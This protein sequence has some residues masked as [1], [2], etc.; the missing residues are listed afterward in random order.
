ME[1]L[2]II[3][4]AIIVALA[5][6][7]IFGKKLHWQEAAGQIGGISLLMVCIVF[8]CSASKKHDTEILNGHVTGKARVQVSCEH[9]YPCHCYSYSCGTAKNP[10]TCQ[11]CDTCYEHPYDIDWNVEATTGLTS[12]TFQVARLDSQGLMEPPRWD[13]F[14]AGDPYMQN[15]SYDNYVKANADTIYKTKGFFAMFKDQIP[16]YP[17]AIQDYHTKLD[18]MLLVGTTLPDIAAWNSD[19]T[20]LNC[21]I[22]PTKQCN[23][24]MIVSTGMPESFYNAVNEAW[25]GGK[26]NDIIVM[27]DQG[28]DGSI[29]WV[30]VISWAKN[31]IMRVKLRDDLLAV[32]RMN[33]SSVMNILNRDINDYFVRKRMREFKYLDSAII[34]SNS[35]FWW[36]LVSALLLSIAISVFIDLNEL[37]GTDSYY[38]RSRY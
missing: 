24:L 10:S 23:I 34:L 15:Y 38:R 29:D 17:E 37:H 11:H 26:K 14:N 3:F 21:N 20:S 25:I 5:N 13:Q 16:P 19:L 12:E 7:A 35:E 33:R 18:R 28:T 22:G 32:G 8:G 30:N 2:G 27:V 4:P 6:W 31:D 36:M 9:S 1:F